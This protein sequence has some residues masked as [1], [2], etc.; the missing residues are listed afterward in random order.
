MALKRLP[1]YTWAYDTAIPAH[2][3]FEFIQADALEFFADAAFISRFDAVHGSPPCQDHSIAAR[4]RASR[5]ARGL[6]TPGRDL[7]GPGRPWVIENV[8]GAPMRA[9][10]LLC[11]CMFGLPLLRRE[12]WFELLARLLDEPGHDHREPVDHRRRAT[13]RPLGAGRRRLPDH[14]PTGSGH[15]DRLDDPRRASPQAIPPAYTE[16]MGRDLLEHLRQAAA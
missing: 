14:A 4:T 2:Y 6:L 3:P 9:D 13:G 8:P 7:Q 10:D 5:A 16:H 12:R 1:N 11:G 15:G